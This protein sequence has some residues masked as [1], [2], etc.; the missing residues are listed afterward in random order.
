M[1]HPHFHAKSSARRFGG[2]ADDYIEI[3]N[4][5]DQTKAH[6][7]DARHRLLL[8]NSFGIFL[9]QQ[10]FGVTFK[11]KSDGREFPTRLVGEQ[12][13]LED[14]G[15]I[16][17]VQQCLDKLPIEPWMVKGARA[18]SRELEQENVP[19]G[20]SETDPGGSSDCD[21]DRSGSGAVEEQQAVGA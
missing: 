16:P 9:C 1:S 4:W 6:M 8:H 20:V 11:R 17:S 10:V 13:V 14:Y 19:H 12:H 7:A 15:F 21:R 3:H 2:E 5:F 18:L